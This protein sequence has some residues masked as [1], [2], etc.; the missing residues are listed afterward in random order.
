MHEEGGDACGKIYDSD[1]D[2]CSTDEDGDDI[3]VFALA[4][5]ADYFDHS[6]DK[7]SNGVGDSSDDDAENNTN[8]S[9]NDEE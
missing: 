2:E 4:A 7:I 1:S 3:G 5:N 8:H 9:D 6:D